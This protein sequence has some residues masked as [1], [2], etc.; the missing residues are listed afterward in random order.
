MLPLGQ[1][2]KA[3]SDIHMSGLLPF[4][5]V[6]KYL[7]KITSSPPFHMFNILEARRHWRTRGARPLP[8]RE[9][10]VQKR[11]DIYPMMPHEEVNC[12]D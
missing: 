8:F 7:D 3:L 6:L 4:F 1:L 5:T 11:A 10:H 9:P 2:K 12:L